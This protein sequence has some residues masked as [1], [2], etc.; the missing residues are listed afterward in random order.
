MLLFYSIEHKK[1]NINSLE[2]D[3]IC[4]A[5]THKDAVWA[6]ALDILFLLTH[7]TCCWLSL[8]TTESLPLLIQTILILQVILHI[9]LHMG[10]RHRDKSCLKGPK[11]D[12]ANKIFPV[13]CIPQRRKALQ[14]IKEWCTYKAE[15]FSS[16]Q[17]YICCL[18]NANKSMNHI[19]CAYAYHVPFA[20]LCKRFWIKSPSLP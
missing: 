5:L 13:T 16:T 6:V 9:R 17:S 10:E 3:I 18:Y 11:D 20:F 15:D 1:T 14:H 7:R 4:E 8:V 2:A 12:M 19:C